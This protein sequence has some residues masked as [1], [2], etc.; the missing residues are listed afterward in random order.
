MKMTRQRERLIE[1]VSFRKRLAHEPRLQARQLIAH[2]AFE[3]GAGY[4]RRHAVDD[5]HVDGPRAHQGIGDLERL[6]ARIGLG[7]EEVLHVDAEL[8][9][10]ARIER[11]LGIDEGAH[12][13]RLLRFGDDLEGQGGLARALRPVDLDDAAA[14]QAADAE[15]DVEP[16][17]AR[18][19]RLGLDRLLALAETHD[20]ALAEGLLDL[21][22]RG[23]ERLVLVHVLLLYETEC[24]FRHDRLLIP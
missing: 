18:G 14:R 11:V 21:R 6:L 4:Q 5:E 23:I 8:L 12:P 9:G 20:R 17:R 10:V 16:E 15:G 1:L 22:E 2:C 7:D 19:H 24:H 3:L 13:A